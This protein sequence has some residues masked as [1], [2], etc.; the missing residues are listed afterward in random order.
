[1]DIRAISSAL[2]NLNSLRANPSEGSSEAKTSGEEKGLEAGA[3]EAAS[4][5]ASQGV[6]QNNALP[7]DQTVQPGTAVSAAGGAAE[8][9]KASNSAA[10]LFEKMFADAPGQGADQK[11]PAANASGAAQQ[12]AAAGVPEAVAAVGGASETERQG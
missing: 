11:D 4:A 12:P 2:P 7:S 9:S 1:M 6:A 5:S 3:S 8:E 10:Q